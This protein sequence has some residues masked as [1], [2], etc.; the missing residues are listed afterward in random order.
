MILV[1][2]GVVLLV[3]WLARGSHAAPPLGRASALEILD[4]RLESGE[5]TPNE[6]RERAEILRGH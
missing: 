5:I 1:L 2:V 6:Y 3:I 4:R